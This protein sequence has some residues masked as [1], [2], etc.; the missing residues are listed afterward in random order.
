MSI[1]MRGIL[2]TVLIVFAFGAAR[3]AEG[4]TKDEAVAMVKK[5]VAA[6]KSEGT[7][8]AYAE[9]IPRARSSTATFTSWYTRWMVWCSRMAETRSSSASIDSTTRT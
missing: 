3:A 1:G 2:L 4:P 7:E 8:K 5:A 6:I 9:M